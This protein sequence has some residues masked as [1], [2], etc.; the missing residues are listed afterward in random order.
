MVRKGNSKISLI[1]PKTESVYTKLVRFFF[2]SKVPS[3]HA[4]DG[5]KEAHKNSI[6]E[7]NFFF[8]LRGLERDPAGSGWPA[9]GT[10]ELGNT[11]SFTRW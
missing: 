11:A 6:L 7:L 9:V 4:W 3:I 8:F 1:L 10:T 2:S 5:K